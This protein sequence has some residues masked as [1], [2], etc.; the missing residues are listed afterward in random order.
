MIKEKR[1]KSAYCYIDKILRHRA[2]IQI[3]VD[4]AR[5]TNNRDNFCRASN[6]QISDPTA[7]KA[8]Q[9]ITAVPFVTL[10]NGFHIKKPEKWLE[11]ANRLFDVLYPDEAKIINML[12]NGHSA[13]KTSRICG[14]SM[15]ALYHLRSE[16]RHILAEI[17]CQYDL[18]SVVE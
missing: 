3:A 8:L 15:S 5:N 1:R 17:A 9:N 6:G 10:S 12:Y 14:V 7:A 16:C 13:I 4:E 11:A 18:I 2:E